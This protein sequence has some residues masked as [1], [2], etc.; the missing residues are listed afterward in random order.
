MG[1]GRIIVCPIVL[2]FFIEDAKIKLSKYYWDFCKSFQNYIELFVNSFQNNI[3]LFVKVAKII[4]GVG[5]RFEAQ[6]QKV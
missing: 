6:A 2:G 4:L 3:G 1:F 5:S